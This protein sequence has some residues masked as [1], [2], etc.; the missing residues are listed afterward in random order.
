MPD[1][2]PCARL[3]VSNDSKSYWRTST[4]RRRDRFLVRRI[5]TENDYKPLRGRE[6]SAKLR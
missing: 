5:A 4:L 1:Q 2:Y 6:P 3:P